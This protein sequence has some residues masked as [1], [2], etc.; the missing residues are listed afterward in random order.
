[1]FVMRSMSGVLVA[2]TVVGVCSMRVRGVTAVSRM[3]LRFVIQVGRRDLYG[4][5]GPKFMSQ[6]LP[7]MLIAGQPEP[8]CEAEGVAGVSLVGEAVATEAI[9]LRSGR[10]RPYRSMRS[11]PLI[12]RADQ[13]HYDYDKRNQTQ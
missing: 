2:V 4:Q 1:V 11:C 12:A 13:H 10:R 7:S 5:R 8:G 3:V 6:S 9:L